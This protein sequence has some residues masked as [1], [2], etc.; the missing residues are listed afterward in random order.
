MIPVAEI[1][2]DRLEP[3]RPGDDPEAFGDR[4]IS[5]FL[6]QGAEL[7]LFRRGRR[8]GTLIVDSAAVPTGP[9]CHPVP[10]A[11][12][13]VELGDAADTASEFLAM[14]RTQAP[15]G[16]ML[17]GGSLEPE[18]R[19]Q[20]VG[21][22]LAERVLRA[23]DAPLPNWSRA[24]R[25]LQ[26]FPVSQARDLGFTATF[27][28]DDELRVGNDDA[29]YSLFIVYTPRAQTGYDTAFVAFTSYTAAGKAA[30]R[31][32]DF[33]D[34]DRD[35]TAELLLEVFGT[36]TSWFEAVGTVEDSWQRIFRHRCEERYSASVP[37][38]S[39]DSGAVDTVEGSPPPGRAA[40]TTPTTR[41][42][43]GRPIPAPQ[44]ADTS[45]APAD[46]LSGVQ[47]RI[48]I[49]EPA[50]PPTRRDSQP[51]SGSVAP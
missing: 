5:S 6:R 13:T 4:F 10:R 16:R 7:T 22:I 28:L 18:P 49:S 3:I 26:P 45:A 2:D 21:N 12:G 15:D 41:P 32:I 27:L 8:A 47:P 51:D 46:P 33:L 17:P 36:R 23:R 34:W 20:V 29:G 35:G 19:M 39:P 38:G 44:P 37:A 48:Q 14:A 1:T 43:R 50:G 30:P 40:P 42:A 31:V 9:A 24:R 25:Q 11:T